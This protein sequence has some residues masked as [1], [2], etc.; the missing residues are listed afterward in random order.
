M[1]TFVGAWVILTGLGVI[2]FAT[3]YPESWMTWLGIFFGVFVIIGGIMV[4]HDHEEN[5]RTMHSD[6]YFRRDYDRLRDHVDNLDMLV[7]ALSN[8][9]LQKLRDKNK[10]LEKV[11]EIIEDILE[12]RKQ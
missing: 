6:A 10:S 12:E 9:D 1:I 8:S 4:L 7:E 5:E 11:V 3:R 2:G